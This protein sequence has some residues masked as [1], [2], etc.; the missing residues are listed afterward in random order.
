MDGS[1]IELAEGLDKSIFSLSVFGRVCGLVL[2][3]SV[4]EGVCVVPQRWRGSLMV[5]CFIRI[6]IGGRKVLQL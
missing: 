1:I 4:L 2:I 6:F 5:G 3:G